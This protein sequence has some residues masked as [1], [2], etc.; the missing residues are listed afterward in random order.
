[1]YLVEAPALYLLSLSKRARCR[2]SLTAAHA[3]AVGAPLSFLGLRC[4]I[5]EVS[6][7]GFQVSSSPTPPAPTVF[8]SRLLSAP[9]M[10]HSPQCRNV[11]RQS[12][13]L[14][15]FPSVLLGSTSATASWIGTIPS[16]EGKLLHANSFA[17]SQEVVSR[18]QYRVCKV[19]GEV[20]LGGEEELPKDCA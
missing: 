17:F 6:T 4:C 14:L 18:V 13:S 8:A 15:G 2:K 1:M 10:M 11:H 12:P 20:L 16:V 19:L 7:L 3:G 9:G 5:D